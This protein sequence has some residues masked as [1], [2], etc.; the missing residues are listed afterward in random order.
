MIF[1]SNFYFTSH[2]SFDRPVQTLGCTSKLIYT[3]I[4]RMRVLLFSAGCNRFIY[5]LNIEH[6]QFESSGG[7]LAIENMHTV[8]NG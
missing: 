7:L 1:S 5:V 8:R 3:S 6:I 2:L 4:F